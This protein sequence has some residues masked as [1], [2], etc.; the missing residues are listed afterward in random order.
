LREEG[1]LKKCTAS[2]IRTCF[3]Q[4]S[5]QKITEQRNDTERKVS[6]W[7]VRQYIGLAVWTCAA[8]VHR[9]LS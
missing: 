5:V 3:R 6:N 2:V 9:S 8:Q 1:K 4:S 7:L